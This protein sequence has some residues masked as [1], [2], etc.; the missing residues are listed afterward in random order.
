M[1]L[2]DRELRPHPFN[3]PSRSLAGVCSDVSGSDAGFSPAGPCTLD[4]ASA[5]EGYDALS[6]STS[7]EEYIFTF[8]VI[9]EKPIPVKRKFRN[10]GVLFLN[11][12][13]AY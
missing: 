12:F 3:C 4:S 5:G 13:G 11:G 6:I 7:F 8:K 10:N 1:S 2:R 9:A